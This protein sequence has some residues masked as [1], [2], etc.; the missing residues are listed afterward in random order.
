MKTSAKWFFKLN[1][2]AGMALCAVA[3]FGVLGLMAGTARR[4]AFSYF[5][6]D[7]SEIVQG[8]FS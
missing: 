2:L 5:Y 7:F 8:G 3:L 4:A 1:A 6:D